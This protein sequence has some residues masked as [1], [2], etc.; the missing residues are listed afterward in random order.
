MRRSLLIPFLLLIVRPLAAKT[1]EAPSFLL[2]VSGPA[3]NAQYFKLDSARLW[4]QCDGQTR[5]EIGGLV[6]GGEP[7]RLDLKRV[8]SPVSANTQIVAGSSHGERTL[9]MP[10]VMTFRGI[11][12]GEAHSSVVISIVGANMFAS[13]RREN[14]DVYDLAPEREGTLHILMRET[15]LLA[16]GEARPL[17]C[18]A[19]D[20]PQP[21]PLIPIADLIHSQGLSSVAPL[22]TTALLQTD[23]AVEAD[24]CFYKAAGGN[25]G[26]VVA[27]IVSMFAMSSVIY[28]DE[29]NIT[30]H[31]SWIKVWTDTDPYNVKGNAYALPDTVKRYWKLNYASVQ[32]D[33]AHV[34]TSIGY[35]GGGYGWYSLCDTNWSYSVSSP[36][37]GGKYPTFA[38]T[39]DA[40]IVAHEIGHNFSLPHSH[41]CYWDPPLDTCYTK[42]DPVH[43][44][45]LGDACDTLPI[46][47]RSSAGTIM[48]YCANANYTL[49]GRDYA[50]F[51]LAMTFSPRVATV[52]RTNAEKAAC[53]K[54]PDSPLVI[55]QYPHGTE[56][57]TADS[58]CP[59][60]WTYSNV[61][62]VTL[63][64]ST[65]GGAY[66]NT[67]TSQLSAGDG[68]FAWKVPRVNS[69]Q[70][71]VRI[72][73]TGND[74][75]ADTSLMFFT[76]VSTASSPG[77]AGP[78]G[79]K[80]SLTLDAS[81]N[82]I[83]LAPLVNSPA[84]RCEIVD[85][86]GNVV[87]KYSG[88]ANPAK[89]SISTLPP[90]SYFV[91]MLSPSQEVLRF[92][93]N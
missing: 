69:S 21:N 49:A 54:S 73:E 2:P 77:A 39:Y 71:L 62:K 8:A 5:V 10:N 31:L 17:N 19:G 78:V 9:A 20:I 44:L 59:I 75:H 3:A 63:E 90:G 6:I 33:L 28:E 40:Y 37:T 89:V 36:T 83:T 93:K 43:G 84:L 72:A 76:V 22:N 57:L 55:L 23:V 79:P 87:Q 81:G 34:M 51:K 7:I 64:Y 42:N 14:G 13:I 38:F 1:I 52:M 58:I 24:T 26:K 88:V 29:A 16:F 4:S 74:Q 15:V 12:A 41:D 32:R 35:G 68:S 11:V 53:V 50:Y 80:F 47:P 66:W 82:W 25:M 45:S 65:N 46:A 86:L 70:M 27:Y 48:S 18:F 85:V 60:K 91:R 67:I 61:Q 92:E 56:T 30:L